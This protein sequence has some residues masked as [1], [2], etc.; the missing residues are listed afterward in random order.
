[1][2]K[3]LVVLLV[4]S[5]T[6]CLLTNLL[7]LLILASTSRKS[8]SQNRGGRKTKSALRYQLM[9][10]QSLVGIFTVSSVLYPL[11]VGIFWLFLWHCDTAEDRVT[12]GKRG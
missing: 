1:M 5:A 11:K 3:L 4:A 7:V 8:K 9:K 6:V 2:E 12:D 10:N